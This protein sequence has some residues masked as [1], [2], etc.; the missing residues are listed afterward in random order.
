MDQVWYKLS[1]WE[2]LCAKK[3]PVTAEPVS[4]SYSITVAQSCSTRTRY[5]HVTRG[6]RLQSNMNRISS[7]VWCQISMDLVVLVRKEFQIVAPLQIGVHHH[8][9]PVLNNINKLGNFLVKLSFICEGSTH[10]TDQLK[11]QR[12]YSKKKIV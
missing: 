12:F 2:Y 5:S 9:R 1:L 7:R 11:K 6:K 4:Y 10:V 8:E 3:V